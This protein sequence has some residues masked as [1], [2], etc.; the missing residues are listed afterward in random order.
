MQDRNGIY[1]IRN[2]HKTTLFL[3]KK[4]QVIRIQVL[5]KE[6]FDIVGKN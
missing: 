1:F 4:M 6:H 5:S 2:Y 3:L